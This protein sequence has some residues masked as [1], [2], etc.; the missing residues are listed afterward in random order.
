MAGITATL[1][2][3][4]RDETNVGMMDCKR[5]LEETEGDK[6]E[7]IKLLREKGVAIAGKRASKTAKEG[8][9]AAS[10]E[11]GGTSSVMIEVNCE[12]DFVARNEVF[13]A[14]V[15]ELVEKAKTVEN[16]GLA[17]AAKDELTDQIAAIGEN[18]VVRRNVKYDVQGNGIVASYIH[19]GGKVG[20][21]VEV[22]CEKEET[23]VSDVFKDAVKDVTLHIAASNP[24]YLVREDV[25][26][27]VIA[28]E[29]E[30]Y[31]KQAEGKPAQI[32]DKIVEG[33]MNKYYSQTC[34]VEQGFVKDPDQSVKDMLAAKGKELEDELVIR[35]FIRYQLGEE[36]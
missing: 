19:L 22:G 7:A 18:L 15:K 14:F 34:L 3:E 17:D 24:Q 10:V 29:R 35:R 2:K 5:A 9:V 28:A 20:V 36:A 21:L 27:D 1:V 13:Q 12:T 26:E 6:T 33:K 25:S 23:K 32:I 30:I 8:Q 31:A 11:T 4:L 16:D